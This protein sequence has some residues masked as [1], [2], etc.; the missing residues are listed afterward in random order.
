MRALD[1]Q[2]GLFVRYRDYQPRLTPDQRATLIR[3]AERS[4]ERRQTRGGTIQ[5]LIA[6]RLAAQNIA[7]MLAVIDGAGMRTPF[8]HPDLTRAY[9]SQQ[10]YQR[11]L[12]DSLSEWPGSAPYPSTGAA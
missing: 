11:G 4:I 10:E 5:S 1:E 2:V 9:E 3:F 6:Q 7:G 8:T 12:E